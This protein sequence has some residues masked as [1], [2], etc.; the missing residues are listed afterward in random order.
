MANCIWFFISILGVI[1]LIP[2]H[3]LSVEHLKLQEKYGK[4]KGDKIAKILGMISGWGFFIFLF[5]IWISPQPR[6][7]IPFFQDLAIVIPIINLSIPLFHLIVSILLIIL[8]AW[9]AIA[10]V[11]EV[12]LKVAETHKPEKVIT[13]GIYSRIR[14]PQYFGTIVV[15]VGF[16]LLLSSLYSLLSTPLII[17]Y[18]Y[19]TSWKEEKELIKEFG[20]E[21]EEY[22]KKVPM[23]YPKL[24]RERKR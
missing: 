19:I 20:K 14:H 3:F 17:F 10:G 23:L 16:S 7:T 13:T 22:K 4:E 2:I 21:Y 12:T 1:C 5:G 24:R 18:N 6:F 8:G 15:H 9:F 11:K